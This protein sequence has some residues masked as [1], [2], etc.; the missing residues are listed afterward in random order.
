MLHLSARVRVAVESHE[1]Q[2]RAATMIAQFL[3]DYRHQRCAPHAT[4]PEFHS[5]SFN[6]ITYARI[7]LQHCLSPFLPPPLPREHTHT[8]TRTHTRA[9]N[10]MRLLQPV[11][12]YVPVLL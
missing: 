3:D 1:H 12:V 4:T 9:V 10:F 8:D 7:A 11:D 2:K 5:D 6:T